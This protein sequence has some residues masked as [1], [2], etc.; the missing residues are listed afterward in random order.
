MG[1]LQKLCQPFEL[2]IFIRNTESGQEIKVQYSETVMQLKKSYK[3]NPRLKVKG[4]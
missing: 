1:Y 3:N 2:R 4:S